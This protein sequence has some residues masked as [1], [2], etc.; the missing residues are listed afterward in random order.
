MTVSARI[1]HALWKTTASTRASPGRDAGNEDLTAAQAGLARFHVGWPDRS[2]AGLHGPRGT[3]RSVR[4]RTARFHVGRLDR[5][6]AGLHGS[7]WD[8]PRRTADQPG[9]WSSVAGLARVPR[10]TARAGPRIK[11]Q[12]VVGPSPDCTV[13]RGTARRP[14][15]ALGPI[16]PSP[17]CTG[18]TWDG[19][20]GPSP[21]ARSHVGRL[22]PDR[23]SKRGRWSVRRRARTVPRGTAR[24]VRRRTAWV[25]RGTAR[26]VA[27]AGCT[28]PRGTARAGPRINADSGRLVVCHRART[29]PTWDGSRRTA[30]QRSR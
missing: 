4:R 11:T 17:D 1:P 13:P 23:G 21:A 14:D 8:G 10:G 26:S 2:V 18:P 22:S 28:V 30:D 20:I 7:T 29:G 25:P 27:V 15:A 12:P 24:S 6:V 9:Q 5:S 19:P 16:G 3:A